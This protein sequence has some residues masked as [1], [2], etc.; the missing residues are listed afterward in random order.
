MKNKLFL[1]G[2]ISIM[3]GFV[4]LVAGCDLGTTTLGSSGGGGSYDDDDDDYGG[5]YDDDDDTYTQW[6]VNNS[7]YTVTITVGGQSYS[8]PSHQEG[9]MELSVQL[10]TYVYQPA[11]LVSAS[12]ALT[13]TITFR[14]R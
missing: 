8:L 13:D 14:N 12:G 1:A 3:L 9:Y 10:V 7:S 6:F 4:L 5:G 2:I 11:N